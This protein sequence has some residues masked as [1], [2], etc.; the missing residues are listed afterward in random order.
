MKNNN[1]VIQIVLGIIFFCLSLFYDQATAVDSYRNI[2][3]ASMVLAVLSLL[4]LLWA[5]WF[6]KENLKWFLLLFI[7]GDAIIFLDVIS[8][9]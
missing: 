2:L 6:S 5:I 8:R 3:I 4:F 1:F 7:L 9:L